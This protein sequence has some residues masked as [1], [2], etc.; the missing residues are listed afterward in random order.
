MSTCNRLDL[1]TLGFNRLCPK[2]SPITVS[3][4]ERPTIVNMARAGPPTFIIPALQ[5]CDCFTREIPVQ[6]LQKKFSRSR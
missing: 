2:I 6:P 1:K 5:Q 3:D 4:Q